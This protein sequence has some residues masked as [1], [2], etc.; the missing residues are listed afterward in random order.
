MSVTASFALYPVARPLI[1]ARGIRG[2]AM[3]SLAQAAGTSVGSINYHIGD[4]NALIAQLISEE[5]AQRQIVHGRWKRRANILMTGQAPVLA[6]LVL[7]YLDEAIASREAAITLCELSLE[8]GLNPA[9]F[10]GMGVLL[11]GEAIFWQELLS[12]FYGEQAGALGYAVASYC[13]DELPFSLALGM[14]AD[15]RLLRAATI[16]RLSEGLAGPATGLAVSFDH[17][18]AACG[19][20][21]TDALYP[22][23]VDLPVGSKKAELAAH[24]ATVISRLGASAVT[25]RAVAAEA[26]ISNSSVAHHFRTHEDLLHAGMGALILQ[27]RRHITSETSESREERRRMAAIR[28]THSIALAACRN[29]QLLPFALDMRR[30]RAE[31]VWDAVGQGLSGRADEQPDKAAIQ[32]AVMVTIGATLAAQAHEKQAEKEVSVTALDMLAQM[33]Q[34]FFRAGS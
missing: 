12:P 6:M 22:L 8:A 34:A 31:N 2:L 30:R 33:R 19:T 16:Q 17:L 5:A 25:H 21:S 26:G 18:V 11:D 14:N 23:V 32:A 28:A 29:P 13:H 27:M 24:V 4:K 10:P 20:K 9:A 7:A 1:A 15:Y 3:R